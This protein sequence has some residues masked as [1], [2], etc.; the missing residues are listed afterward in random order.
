MPSASPAAAA[1]SP[2]AAPAA[3]APEKVFAGSEEATVW[4]TSKKPRVKIE[5]HRGFTFNLDFATHGALSLAHL[6]A[7]LETQPKGLTLPFDPA[8]NC[9]SVAYDT[10][11]KELQVLLRG[12][13][14]PISKFSF[15]LTGST[16]R[17]LL[18]QRNQLALFVIPPDGKNVVLAWLGGVD[19]V[20]EFRNAAQ[21]E[22]CHDLKI[23]MGGKEISQNEF[24]KGI[25]L[26][27]PDEIDDVTVTGTNPAGEPFR[28]RYAFNGAEVEKH[29]QEAFTI[30]LKAAGSTPLDDDGETAALPIPDPTE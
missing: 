14:T 22:L 5:T 9:L 21:Y 1:A 11:A 17:V 8:A 13:K 28:H 16:M 25:K 30:F 19:Y 2:A 20:F 26:G 15:P 10:E 12:G 4:I 6:C 27:S 23:T 29:A 3:A 7:A 24:R 18:R